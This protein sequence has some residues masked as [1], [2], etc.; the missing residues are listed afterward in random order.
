MGKSVHTL[1]QRDH[2]DIIPPPMLSSRM[3][4]RFAKSVI[5]PVPYSSNGYPR[6]TSTST[7]TLLRRYHS[8]GVR[9]F[10]RQRT[11]TISGT[12]EGV[13]RAA[14][15]EYSPMVW[16]S[17]RNAGLERYWCSRR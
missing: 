14:V 8:P 17:F 15:T 16:M 10:E 7:E 5:R 2:D 9:V 11:A 13:H 6:E 12:H 4:A 1:V 3:F